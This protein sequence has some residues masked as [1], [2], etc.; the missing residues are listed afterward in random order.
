MII[1]ELLKAA[2]DVEISDKDIEELNARLLI[3]EEEFSDKK[4]AMLAGPDFMS[5]TYNL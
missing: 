4:R 1:T 2:M 3:A 5:R